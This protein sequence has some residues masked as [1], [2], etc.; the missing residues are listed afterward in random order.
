MH[1]ILNKPETSCVDLTASRLVSASGW[2][3]MRKVVFSELE[4][5]VNA[6]CAMRQMAPSNVE[7]DR[8]EM[9]K[10]HQ[11][12]MSY[13]AEQRSAVFEAQG[14]SVSG[15]LAVQAISALAQGDVQQAT[16]I[17]NAQSYSMRAELEQGKILILTAQETLLYEHAA[18]FI[19][20]EI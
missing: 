8:V 19:G 13:S 5:I 14:M 9:E 1:A 17:L 2:L 12:A 20:T 18:R 11:F 3:Y 6:I 7:P 10:L 16:S 4:Q 15:A